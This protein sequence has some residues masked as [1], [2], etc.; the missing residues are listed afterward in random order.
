LEKSVFSKINIG[1][2]KYQQ[3]MLFEKPPSPSLTQV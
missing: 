3:L 1:S 2:D